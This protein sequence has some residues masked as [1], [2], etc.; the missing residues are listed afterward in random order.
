M[1]LIIAG[2]RIATVTTIGLV[3]V[4]RVIGE[5]GLGQVMLTGLQPLQNRR[6]CT[7]P[8]LTV[9][10]AV[11]ADLCSSGIGPLLTPWSRARRGARRGLGQ[12]V[13]WFSTPTGR[14]PA[15]SRPA[16]SS[17]Y[18]LR[19]ASIA[20]FIALPSASIIGHTTGPSSWR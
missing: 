11:A 3:M 5:G 12:V 8:L 1:P 14:A 15:G 18:P 4:T 20:A 2:L 13:A 16:P 10:L 17:T 9:A 19:L 6:S 7:A